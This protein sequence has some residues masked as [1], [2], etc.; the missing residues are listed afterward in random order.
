MLELT[1]TP[2]EKKII[3]FA[4]DHS[5]K[6]VTIE[7]IESSLGIKSPSQHLYKLVEK[8]V[9]KRVGDRTYAIQTDER[10]FKNWQP[11]PYTYIRALLK[12]KPYYVGGPVALYFNHLTDQVYW[13][14]ID[15]FS[16]CFYHSRRIGYAKADFHR[17]KVQRLDIGTEKLELEGEGVPFSNKEKTL[18]DVLEYPKHFGENDGGIVLV[19][20][21]LREA[22]V[23]RLVEYALQIGKI[24]SCQRLGVL[25]DRKHLHPSNYQA[26][27]SK[28]ALGKSEPAMISTTDRKGKTNPKWRIIEND[29]KVSKMALQWQ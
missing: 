25:L 23:E 26:L 1:L 22:N 16:P 10:L 24:S 20:R 14:I 3:E 5:L 7:E 15:V 19:S 2:T 18:L 9:S 29:T 27:I 8:G 4:K 17:M 6:S 12:D 28:V 13:S 21:S 11:S